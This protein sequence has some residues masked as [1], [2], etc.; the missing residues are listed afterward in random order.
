METAQPRPVTPANAPM[1]SQL[2]NT[3]PLAPTRPRM[4]AKRVDREG[5]R[6][7]PRPGEVYADEA[8][9]GSFS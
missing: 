2:G 3:K 1:S 6:F 8:K 5:K 7:G 9:F 4:E